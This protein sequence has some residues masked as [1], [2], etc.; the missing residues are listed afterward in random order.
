MRFTVMVAVLSFSIVGL[1]KA[2]DVRAS[3]RKPTNIPAEALAPALT[4][5]ARDRGFQVVFRSEIVGK[6]QTH[7]AEG[8]LTIA[9]ALTQLLTGTDL[10]FQYLDSR[11]ITIVKSGDHAGSG[12]TGPLSAPPSSQSTSPQENP[13]SPFRLAQANSAQAQAA[14]SGVTGESEDDKAKGQREVPQL[15]QIVVTGSH[16]KTSLAAVTAP[17]IIITAAEIK[18]MGFNTAEDVVCSLSQ[19]FSSINSASTLDNNLNTND[20]QGQA[21]ADLRGL[22]PDNTL[23]LV[24]GR[25]RAVSST[26]GDIVNLNTIPVGAIDRVEIMT[27]GASAVYGSDAVAGVINFILKKNYQGGET[28]LR[29][30]IGAN[31]GDTSTLEQDLGDH[32]SSGDVTFSGRYSRSNPVLSSRAGYTTSDFTNIGWDDWRVTTQGQP[33]VVAGLGSLPANDNGTDGI[34][35][36]L[37]PANI[38]PYDKAS[39]PF[40]VVARTSN[41]SF[42]LNAEQRLA[43]GIQLYGEITYA[44]NTSFSDD[45]PLQALSVGV[46]A[47]NAYNNLGMPVTV[48]YI[49]ERETQDGLMP[50]EQSLSD[51]RAL[52]AILGLKITLPGDW[53]L[54]VS[55]NHSREDTTYDESQIDPTLLAQHLSGVN[56]QGQPVPASQQLNLFGN[57]TAQSAA[58]VA[59]LVS[60]NVPG[61]VEPDNF[62]TEDDGQITAQGAVAKLPGGDLQ[63][64][65]G[66]EFRRETLDYPTPGVGLGTG[67]PARDVKAA[68]AELNAP[69]VGEG[70][71]LPGIYALNVYG[72]ARW[73]EYSIK[74][75]FDGPDAP[76]S[77][78]T[79]SKA[80]PKVGLSWFPVQTLKFRATYGRAFV[81]PLLTDMFGTTTGPIPNPGIPYVDPK[82]PQ[83]GFIY[84]PFYSAYNSDLRPETAKDSTVGLD[85]N[86]MGAL[87]GLAVTV[88]YDRIDFSNLIVNAYEYLTDPSVLFNLPGVIQRNSSGQVT[89]IY[90]EAVNIGDRYSRSI[91]AS[92]NYDLDTRVGRLSFGASG[93]Y[94]DRLEDIAAPGDA[95]LILE[96]TQDGPE[97]VKGRAWTTWARNNYGIDLYAN[98][99]SSYINTDLISPAQLGPQAVKHYTTFDLTGFYSLPKGITINAGARNLTNAKPPF[100]NYY[101]PWDSRRV[102]LRGR[103]VYLELVAR[104]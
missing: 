43:S 42:D 65:A 81:A 47:D 78:V 58:A 37:S 18:A 86:P 85:W 54:D 89:G 24:N 7:G 31:G 51:Q 27:D 8:E 60:W 4:Q 33:G 34:A 36:K 16:L 56:A 22:G 53:T 59:G 87:R 93:T 83:E 62:A 48:R 80:S 57:G 77:E 64:A 45:G 9:E 104:Y 25:R 82:N 72:A 90:L 66:G 95:P 73:E 70:N 94:T 55:A 96:G 30:D 40:D 102:D 50:P 39:D 19:D 101:E 15:Q 91:D 17:I 2:D 28:H 6:A 52:G 14:D 46:P 13:R 79:F 103:I 88:T 71:R 10:A 29:E 1:A 49:F 97:R 99:A 3:I 11:T 98:Y 23:I 38:V 44:H 69:L 84:P 61:Y 5:L 63:L 75:Q 68:Y 32:W 74:G 12:P 100:F 21:A 67:H 26:F 20:S 92:I 76:D 41:L 35:G